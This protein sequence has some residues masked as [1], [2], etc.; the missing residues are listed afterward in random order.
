MS[1]ATTNDKE[2][3]ENQD[4]SYAEHSTMMISL[5]G[6]A[7]CALASQQKIANTAGTTNG[8]QVTSM[9]D[10]C[11]DPQNASSSICKCRTDNTAPGCPGFIGAVKNEGNINKDLGGKGLSNM[12]GLSYGKKTT[13]PGLNDNLDAK[14]DG[15]GDEAKKAFLENSDK[16]QEGSPFGTASAANLGGIGSTGGAGGNAAGVDKNKMVE[17]PKSFGSSF[18]NSVGSMFRGSGGGKSSS[19]KDDKILADKYKEQIK[20]Q[21]AAE[22]MRSEISSASGTD[23]WTKIRTRYKSNSGSLIDSN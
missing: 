15:L 13:T 22:Q 6:L 8:A 12:A 17:E 10:M 4:A 19:P 9:A 18:I 5:A 16:K 1:K 11:L 2:A 23:N 21:I 3:I 20:R 14:L 7:A